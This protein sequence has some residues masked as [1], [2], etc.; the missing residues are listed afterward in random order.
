M[1]TK[2]I[3]VT[4]GVCS[5][6]GKGLTAAAIGMLFGSTAMTS[7][8]V[9]FFMELIPFT[10]RNRTN[11]VVTSRPHDEHAVWRGYS[12][13]V[14][15]TNDGTVDIGRVTQDNKLEKST[16]PMTSRRSSTDEET[17]APNAGPT[18]APW[19]RSTALP[20]TANSRNSCWKDEP[21]SRISAT[22]WSP[23]LVA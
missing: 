19:A 16:P 1:Q 6:L 4:G 10:T 12:P 21:R 14:A 11:A 7:A 22:G 15:T 8:A 3:F 2:F 20:F 23:C 9:S 13:T 5:S 17:M 18:I